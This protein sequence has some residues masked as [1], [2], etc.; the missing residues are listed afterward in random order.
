MEGW[1]I[2]GFFGSSAL[3]SVPTVLTSAVLDPSGT[4]VAILDVGRNEADLR[5]AESMSLEDFRECTGF[6]SATP[7]PPVF[8][9]PMAVLFLM[10]GGLEY[11]SVWEAEMRMRAFVQA[12]R[13]E[14]HRALD[15]GDREAALEAFDLA[16]RVSNE[17]EDITRVAEL[18]SP[19]VRAFFSQ[20]LQ[21]SKAAV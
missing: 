7:L 18:G 1:Q 15:R 5:A 11:V 16:R 4:R 17:P 10:D 20:Q 13:S 6:G 3:S 19:D 14:G 2:I 21:R 8:W 12:H 9:E